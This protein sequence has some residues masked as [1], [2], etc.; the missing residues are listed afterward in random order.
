MCSLV[1]RRTK[2]SQKRATT[3]KSV[4]DEEGEP[5]PKKQEAVGDF[6]SRVRVA[7]KKRCLSDYNWLTIIG[8]FI[9]RRMIQNGIAILP[10]NKIKFPDIASRRFPEIAS[11]WKATNARETAKRTIPERW[12]GNRKV[13]ILFQPGSSVKEEAGDGER[14]IWRQ[15]FVRGSKG[16][17]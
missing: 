5:P 14:R 11:N 12:D 1:N 6:A 10:L 9:S 3:I 8:W 2:W 4:K 17:T 7:W 13:G 16:P 15:A